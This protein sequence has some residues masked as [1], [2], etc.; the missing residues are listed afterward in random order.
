MAVALETLKLPFAGRQACRQYHCTGLRP[1]GD[2]GVWGT[3][4]APGWWWAAYVSC[5]WP[6]KAALSAWGINCSLAYYLFTV[7]ELGLNQSDPTQ[8]RPGQG[9]AE[10]EGGSCFLQVTQWQ[11]VDCTVMHQVKTVRS[12]MNRSVITSEGSSSRYPQQIRHWGACS[13]GF[14]IN[15]IEQWTG[16]WFL[17][18]DL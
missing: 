1:T 15:F 14:I 12:L 2:L 18:N 5:W 4:G 3:Y 13:T 10:M 16:W 8:A 17:T 9:R 11:Y 6:W 7:Y